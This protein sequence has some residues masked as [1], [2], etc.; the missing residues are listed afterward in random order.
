[1]LPCLSNNYANANVTLIFVKRP[2]Q[3]KVCNLRLELRIEQN[4]AR[5]DVSVNDLGFR[6]LMKVKD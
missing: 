1:M 3:A 4:I 2:C 5:F 6:I